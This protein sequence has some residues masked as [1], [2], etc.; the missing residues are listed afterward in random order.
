MTFLFIPICKA[1]EATVLGNE[2]VPMAIPISRGSKK[3]LI[4][5]VVAPIC[6]D[7][8]IVD[9]QIDRLN[10]VVH[11]EGS[12]TAAPR[13]WFVGDSLHAN[14]VVSKTVK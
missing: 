1:F 6:D 10:T 11:T 4:V 3:S 2:L 14:K 12:W 9:H 7:T 13:H 8:A 5:S